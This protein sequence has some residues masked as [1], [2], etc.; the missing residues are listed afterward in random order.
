MSRKTIILTAAGIL[1][2]AV[3]IVSCVT[4]ADMHSRSYKMISQKELH[5]FLDADLKY[6]QFAGPRELNAAVEKAVTS[7]YLEFRKSAEKNWKDT[8][9]IRK[10]TGATDSTPPFEYTVV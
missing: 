10:E 2:A 1:A 7:P 3:S 5:K 9:S 4:I 6:P 8:D